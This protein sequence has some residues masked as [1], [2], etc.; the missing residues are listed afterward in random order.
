[1]ERAV[2]SFTSMRFRSDQAAT[3]AEPKL[4]MTVLGK[5]INAHSC[6]L[7]DQAMILD[8]FNDLL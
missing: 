6:R 5:D 1:M 7:V 8:C 4:T 3:G 2:P